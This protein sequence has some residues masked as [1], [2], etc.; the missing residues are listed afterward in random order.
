MRDY[1]GWHGHADL[2]DALTK[3]YDETQKTVN[4]QNGMMEPG[5]K[6]A[7]ELLLPAHERAEKLV[8]STRGSWPSWIARDLVEFCDLT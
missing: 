4:L 2:K 5:Q 8:S 7:L 1:I 6:L 3:L